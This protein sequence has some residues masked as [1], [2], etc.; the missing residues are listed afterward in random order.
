[1]THAGHFFLET[2]DGSIFFQIHF[3]IRNG[4]KFLTGSGGFVIDFFLFPFS[5]TIV[6]GTRTFDENLKTH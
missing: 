5:P 4:Q 3:D 2:F 1:M 6:L